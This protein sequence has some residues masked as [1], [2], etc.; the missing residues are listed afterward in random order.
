MTLDEYLSSPAFQQFQDE[1]LHKE[2]VRAAD[3][4]LER[5]DAVKSHQLYAIP[6]VIQGGGLEGIVEL[7]SKQKEKNSN[8]K[9]KAFWTEIAA[10][11][12]KTDSSEVSLFH[13]LK[14]VLLE[15][16]LIENEE[17]VQDR[18]EQKQLRKRNRSLVEIVMERLLG[19]YFEH[20]ICHYFYKTSQGGSQ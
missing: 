10:I 4:I 7:A 16:G 14:S 12:S 9:N 6:A 13:F 8:T 5:T 2:A 17:Q 3:N 20:F 18:K 15:R 11:L 1:N 19:V